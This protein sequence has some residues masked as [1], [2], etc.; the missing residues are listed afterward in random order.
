MVLRYSYLLRS[1]WPRLHRADLLAD[2]AGADL[3]LDP[4]LHR[5]A[6]RIFLRA[7][8]RTLIG[9]MLL[10]EILFRGQLGFSV[11]FLEEM[12]ARNLGNLLMSPLRPAEFIAALMVMSLIRLVDRHGAGLSHRHGILRLQCLGA[13]L[14]VRLLLRQSDP[15]QLGDRHS[16]FRHTAALRAGRGK[17]GLDAG[18]PDPAARPAFIIRWRYCPNGCS[19]YPGCCRRPMYSRDCARLVIDHVFR[20]D[21]M[22]ARFGPQHLYF[23]T[24]VFAFLRLLDRRPT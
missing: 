12:W 13:R 3:G 11:S 8:A 7:P 14:R 23:A 9:A 16:R 10:W 1:S 6:L 2:G 5:A 4:D 17:P 22:L 21:L 20:A 24:A 19:R 15:D 18:V